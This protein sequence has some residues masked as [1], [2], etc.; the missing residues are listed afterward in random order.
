MNFEE[1][2]KKVLVAAFNHP[3]ATKV[4]F[5]IDEELVFSLATLQDLG[6]KMYTQLI[7]RGARS[8]DTLFGLGVL[9]GSEEFRVE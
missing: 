8:F 3:G 4:Y 7:T 1:L 2:R 6:E 9:W 5:T